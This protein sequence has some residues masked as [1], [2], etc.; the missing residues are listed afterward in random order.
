MDPSNSPCHSAFHCSSNSLCNLLWLL[1]TEH[2]WKGEWDGRAD[3]KKNDTKPKTNTSW[4]DDMPHGM[5]RNGHGCDVPEISPLQWHWQHGHLKEMRKC[6]NIHV[7]WNCW[8]I[9]IK[10][11]PAYG[12]RVSSNIYRSQ[13]LDLILGSSSFWP[14]SHFDLPKTDGHA[15]IHSDSVEKDFRVFLHDPKF[16]VQRMDNFLVPFLDLD[17]PNGR[18]Y[19]LIATTKKRMQRPGKF[20]CNP[21]DRYNFQVGTK[22]SCWIFG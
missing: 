8:P 12:G 18:N 4:S 21:D 13:S 3:S 14:L 1:W 22:N 6:K 10:H 9:F 17:K 15:W 20:D 7:E 19:R 16:F 11:W 5:E 2:S